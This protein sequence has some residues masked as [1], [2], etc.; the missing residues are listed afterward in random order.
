MNLKDAVAVITGGG[1]GLGAA[2]AREFAQHGAKIAILD[3]LSSPGAKVAEEFGYEI[4]WAYD[5]TLIGQGSGGADAVLLVVPELN[6]PSMPGI[7][8]NDFA[9]LS[10]NLQANALQYAD[11]AAPVEVTT[12]IPEGLDVTSTMRVSS[13]WCPRG[14][15][16]TIASIPY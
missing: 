1:S 8:T 11:V 16:I 5:D 14:Q 12:P 13:G 10:P 15:A 9:T 7:N 4:D 2:T 3:L 6:V